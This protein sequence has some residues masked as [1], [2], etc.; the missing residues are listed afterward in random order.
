MNGRVW[1][2]LE[3]RPGPDN[4]AID[5]TLLDFADQEGLCM[6]RLYRWHPYCL[7]FGRHEPALRRYDRAEIERRGLSTV[8]RPTGGRAVW[9]ARE[10]TYALAAPAA[11]FGPLPTAYRTIHATIASALTA[12]G[13]SAEL[14]APESP[15]PLDAGA[16]FARPVGGEVI[17]GG[18]KVVGSAQLREGAAF[19]QHGSI[20]LDDDQ[21]VVAEV[22]RG[23]GVAGSETPLNALLP[24]PVSAATVARAFRECASR[25]WA[26]GWA[27]VEAAQVAQLVG[28]SAAHLGRFTAESWTWRR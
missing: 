14:A 27:P 12:L 11:Q 16:C 21:S 23:D 2:D 8:R 24:E 18:R 7:S 6:L 9:H 19:L 1:V 10:L 3:P 20:L 25:A 5:Q 4:M 22:M 28:D 13:A 15:Q 17:A 26:A